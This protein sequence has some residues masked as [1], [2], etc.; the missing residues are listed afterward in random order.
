M[1]LYTMMPQELIFPTQESE[2][3]QQMEVTYDGVPVM[4]EQTED[5]YYQII[6]VISSNPD[7]FLDP[8]YTP[9]TKFSIR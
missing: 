9:G 8:K 2:F 1:I 7:H 5:H 3:G 4:V 6:R